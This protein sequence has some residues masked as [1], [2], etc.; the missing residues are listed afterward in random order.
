V[1]RQIIMMRFLGRSFVTS[2]GSHRIGVYLV[3]KGLT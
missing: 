3:D 1:R 2:G